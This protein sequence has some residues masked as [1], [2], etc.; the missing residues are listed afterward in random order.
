MHKS[1][2]YLQTTQVRLTRNPFVLTL[3][4]TMISNLSK[5]EFHHLFVFS[6]RPDIVMSRLA[7]FFFLNFLFGPGSI[8][9]SHWL[10]LFWTSCVLPHGFQIQSGYLACTLSCL[11]A[12]ILKVTTGVTPAFSTNRSVHC[13]SVYTA[14][15]ARLLSHALGFEPPTQWWAAQWCVTKSD[16]LPTE[17]FRQRLA[18]FLTCQDNNRLYFFTSAIMQNWSF[19]PRVLRPLVNEIYHGTLSNCLLNYRSEGSTAECEGW[20]VFLRGLSFSRCL[21]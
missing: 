5:D 4:L 21:S 6:Q 19:Y 2:K 1:T 7:T 12:V 11:H 8:L 15:L 10:L 14:W 3:E 18:T 13:I 17:L 20:M 16:T 9:W